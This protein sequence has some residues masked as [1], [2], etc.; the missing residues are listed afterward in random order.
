MNIARKAA[1]LTASA[2]LLALP[3]PSF[4]A[5]DLVYGTNPE[6]DALCNA[7]QRPSD[8][9]GYTTFATN[10]QSTS[11]SSTV[12]S[13]PT[14]ST[15][16][17]TATYTRTYRNAHVNGQSVNIHAYG[18]RIATYA[19]GHT[20]TTP[21]TTT[22]ITTLTGS[23]HVHKLSS[24]GAEDHD[25][26]HEGYNVPPPGLQTTEPVGTAGTTTITYGTRTETFAGPWVDPNATT[27]NDEFVICISPTRNPGVWRSQNGYTNQL[28]QV[29][30]TAW[31]NTL[32]STPSVSVPPV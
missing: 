2:A 16:I 27:Y 14:V 30:S 24:G 6:L 29:C 25:G 17:G 31:Y 21:T 5:I 9:S 4:A 15:G 19:N 26:D 18:D 23:C 8:A 7:L 32:G 11:S 12:D 3:T 13:G 20:E 22:T 28:G 10:I 1:F